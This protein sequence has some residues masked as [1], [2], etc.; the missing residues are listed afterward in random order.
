V[1]LGYFVGIGGMPVEPSGA[2]CY[3]QYPVMRRWCEQV[4]SW[5]GVEMRPVLAEDHTG[6]LIAGSIE[7]PFEP[8]DL[9]VRPDFLYRGQIRQ[10]VHAIGVSDILAE[11]GIYPDLIVGTSLGGLIAACLAGSI[12]REDLFRLFARVA[13]MP[14]APDGESA[15]GIAII[16]LP[17][18]TDIDWYYGESRPHVNMAA[19]FEHTGD[20][21]VMMLSGYLEDLESLAAEAPSGH[22]Q[23]VTG[24]IG[25]VHC[26]DLQFMADLLEPFLNDINFRDPEI[27]L[28]CGV[29]GEQSKIGAELK[30]GDE[31]RH[32][33]LANY[34]APVGSFKKIIAALAE[35]DMQM[36][37]ATG[38]KLPVT[39]PPCP[40]PLLQ[41]SVPDDI[42]RIMTMIYD[43]G[44]VVG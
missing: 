30:T 7:T 15:R 26:P 25:A 24:A 28:L 29:G 41:A 17:P 8:P 10:A 16:E 43:L 1:A 34:V 3:E 35:H 36:V 40:F 6:P 44:L 5:T 9:S 42:G 4:E 38:T 33:I 11:Q 14:L 27:P 39:V 22:V 2:E 20:S 13:E 37:L 19:E 12:A 21:T 23:V 32:S 18:G 31:V